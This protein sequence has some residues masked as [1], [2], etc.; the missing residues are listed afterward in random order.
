[1]RR[2]SG[3]LRV[4]DGL[5]RTHAQ[6]VTAVRAMVGDGKVRLLVDAPRHP[7]VDA[8]DALRKGDLLEQA[9]GARLSLEWMGADKRGRRR[10]A[11]GT[12][13]SRRR[14]VAKRS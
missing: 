11:A 7:A 2:L 1:M 13:R 14:A 8:A 3:I 12:G 6:L 4:A 5:D 10:G 9:L